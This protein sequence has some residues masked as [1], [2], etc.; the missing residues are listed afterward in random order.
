MSLSH[1]VCFKVHLAGQI[2]LTGDECDTPIGFCSKD[3][4]CHTRLKSQIPTK[5]DAV[6]IL[7][8]SGLL[9]SP[10]HVLDEGQADR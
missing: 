5:K 4:A 8:S 2:W 6:G 7:R 9:R 3:W 10:D 1:N